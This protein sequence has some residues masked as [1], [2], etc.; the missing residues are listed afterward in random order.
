VSGAPRDTYI[1]SIVDN[2]AKQLLLEHGGRRV[3]AECMM[4]EVKSSNDRVDSR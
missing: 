3:R 4:V 1:L 2:L